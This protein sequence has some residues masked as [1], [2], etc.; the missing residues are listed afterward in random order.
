V[1]SGNPEQARKFK[2]QED[3]QGTLVTDPSL[4]TYNIAGMKR[5]VLKTLNPK[6][7]L[8]AVRALGGGHRQGKNAGDPWQQGGLL[9]VDAQKRGG[10]LIMQHAASEAGDATDFTA[11]VRALDELAPGA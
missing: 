7:A 10:R 2:E 9:V 6:S 4:K 1:G 5:G 11:V 8:H 3:V